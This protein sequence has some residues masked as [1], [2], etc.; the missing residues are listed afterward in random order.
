MPVVTEIDALKTVDEALSAIDE[1]ARIRVL[2][3]ANSKFLGSFNSSVQSVKSFIPK[4][5]EQERPHSTI[6]TTQ[7]T[8]SK[9]KS[10]KKNQKTYNQI[11][12]LNFYPSEK[13]SA[14]DFVAEK[15]PTTL[16][17]KC[18]VA[19]YYLL[20]ILDIEQASVDHIYTFFKGCNWKLPA[21][22]SNM[23]YQSGSAGWLDT[24]DSEDIKLT[25]I[26]ENLVEHEL[27]KKK[28]K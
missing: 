28:Q 26:G 19:L 6:Q 7:K 23:L 16:K 17:E 24:A 13:P 3:W 10:T 12:E 1:N 22:L 14:Q 2:D 18:V 9:A 4:E 5:G 27:P 15:N 20:Q 21:D 25:S 8:S 11:K